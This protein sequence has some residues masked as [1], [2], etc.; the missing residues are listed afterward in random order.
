ML[1]NFFTLQTS[2]Y[3]YRRSRHHRFKC[4]KI[5]RLLQLDPEPNH[6]RDDQPGVQGRLHRHRVPAALLPPPRP[7]APTRKLP[8]QRDRRL[9]KVTSFC[10]WNK[11]QR[12]VFISETNK[13]SIWDFNIQQQGD[14]FHRNTVKLHWFYFIFFL[15]KPDTAFQN[16]A[17]F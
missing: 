16:C 10:I 17:K 14:T 9:Y 4:F 1:Q 6:L 12:L 11:H 2:Q 8:R 5:C 7:G 13:T 3:F 15:K